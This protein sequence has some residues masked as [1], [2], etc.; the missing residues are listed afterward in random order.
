MARLHWARL[1][2]NQDLREQGSFYGKTWEDK[3]VFTGTLEGTRFYF[4]ARLERTKTA[5]RARRF[6]YKLNTFNTLTQSRFSQTR[7]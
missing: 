6:H 4:I 7:D 1:F 3:T 2:S 5:F